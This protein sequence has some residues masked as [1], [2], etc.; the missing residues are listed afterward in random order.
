MK[1]DMDLR[2]MEIFHVSANKYSG[3]KYSLDYTVSLLELILKGFLFI[4][5]YK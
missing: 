3:N 4:K 2:V 1:I 5:K